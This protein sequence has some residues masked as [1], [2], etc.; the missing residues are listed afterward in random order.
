MK[1]HKTSEEEYAETRAV[2]ES[3]PMAPIAPLQEEETSTLSVMA[4]AFASLVDH[5][6]GRDEQVQRMTDELRAS[7]RQ[8]RWMDEQR[9]YDRLKW[10]DVMGQMERLEEAVRVQAAAM[11]QYE[12]GMAHRDALLGR[13]HRLI[14][15]VDTARMAPSSA[16]LAWVRDS[17]ALISDM[18][19]TP[20][21][22]ST[23]QGS[24]THRHDD[25]M[26][27]THTAVEYARHDQMDGEVKVLRAEDAPAPVPDDA[28][29]QRLQEEMHA[30]RRALRDARNAKSI[31]E[32]EARRERDRQYAEGSMGAPAVRNDDE[33]EEEDPE[34]YEG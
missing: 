15:T 31:A 21:D 34:E 24:V 26:E 1:D 25:G 11:A 9:R 20:P 4:V 17:K 3:G 27:H 13:A 19:E 22:A 29:I 2:N 8:N 33:L 32:K 18:K 16:R 14:V 23:S 30:A 28:T 7:Y 12:A 5:G 10:N 6:I